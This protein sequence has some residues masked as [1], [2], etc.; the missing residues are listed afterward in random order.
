MPTS[1]V[2]IRQLRFGTLNLQNLQLP[3]KPMYHGNTLSKRAYEAKVQWLGEMVRRMDVHFLTFQELWSPQC[4]HDVLAAAKLP[5]PMTV[6]TDLKPPEVGTGISVAL[7]A[8]KDVH[9]ARKRWILDFPKEVQLRKRKPTGNDNDND[10]DYEMS[11]KI[12]RFS[13]P[14][15]TARLEL[16]GRPPIHVFGAHLKSKLAI[17]LDKQESRKGAIKKHADTLGSALATIRR[18]AE[19]T[20][21][22]VMVR[23]Q[24]ERDENEAVIV[25]GDLNDTTYSTTTA[26][27]SGQPKFRLFEKAGLRDNKTGLYSVGL[28]QDLASFRDTAYTYV[29]NGE[30]ESLDHIL[31]SQHLYDY[32]TRRS[33]AFRR[34]EV[35]NDHLD[36]RLK[37]ES[38]RTAA[39]KL[40]RSTLSDHAGIVA[41]FDYAP[42]R[43]R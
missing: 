19:A 33:W 29:H 26:I 41:V 25:M 8:T 17:R 31:V 36:E 18:T 9:I 7:A 22:R 16:E 34:M 15:L 43:R 37:H 1:S 42:A 38:Q 4:L 5:E 23:N 28:M 2:K 6:A 14:V 3:D 20:A 21:L 11:V 12:D 32:S 13:R 24:L 30:R 39:A 10:I 40:L 35:Y 27:I